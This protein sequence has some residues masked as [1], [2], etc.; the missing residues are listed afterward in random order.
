MSKKQIDDE[1]LDAL[2]DTKIKE[3]TSWYGSKLSSERERV[4]RYYNGEYPRRQGPGS[5]SYV[6]PEVY[7]SVEAMK[8]QLLETFAGGKDI[9]RFDPN[10][11]DD[12][13]PARIATAYTS[14]NVFQQNDGYRII[15]DAIHDGLI[16]RIGVAKVFWEEDCDY[17]DNEFDNLDEDSVH[18]LAAQ[19][20]VVNLAA[21][22]DETTGAYKGH[23]VRKIDKGRVCIEVINPEDLSVEPQTKKM[24]S[25]YFMVHRQLKQQD[26]LLKEGFPRKLIERC[27]SQTDAD[28]N[29]SPEQQARFQQIDSGFRNSDNNTDDDTRWLVVNECYIKI[30]RSGDKYPKLYKVLRCG[31]VTLDIEEVDSHPFVVWSPIPIPHSFYGDNFAARVVPIQNIRS[32]LVRAI[33][34]HTSITVNPRYTVLK[35]GLTNPKELLDNRLGGIVNVTRPDAVNPLQ[36]ANLNPFVFQT[37][38]LMQQQNEETTGISSLS[39][40]LNKDAVS[41]QNSQGMVNDLVNM[42]QTRQKVI[43]RNFANQFI[44]PLW[45]KVYGLIVAKENKRNIIEVA[46]NWVPVDPRQWGERKHVSC[47]VHLGYG[48]MD[49]EAMKLIQSASLL[50]K[51]PQLDS[52]FQ[53][54]G[55]YKMASDILNMQ[56][57]KNVSDYLTPPDQ[58]PPPQPDPLKVQQLQIE[59]QKAAALTE[60]A[61]A[62]SDKV[63]M[64]GAIEEMREKLKRI[65]QDFQDN[66]A[67]RSEARKD[68]DVRNRIDIAQREMAIA[69]SIP[70]GSESVSIV[71]K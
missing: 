51:D 27:N 46:G 7:N 34:D 57:I 45:L 26:E 41:N 47:S 60:Q 19:E 62:A 33:V 10:G 25:R 18:G 59:Q 9:V 67:S 52:M 31:N 17:E 55:R 66:I 6:S 58:L 50:T 3:S 22:Q 24:D 49:R 8:A 61:Q 5:S 15:G 35:G 68:A 43:A 69:E 20:D 40:G 28:I 63:K 29:S 32:V 38:G 56:G 37:L 70:P 65:Q 13:E 53:A 21:E 42:S 64:H 12:V 2:I 11:P 54:P 44:I 48:E 1:E 23:M 4:T 36:T 16:A 30:A 71:P 39:Q 14:F